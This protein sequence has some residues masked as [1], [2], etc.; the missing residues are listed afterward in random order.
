MIKQMDLVEIDV[1][2]TE[3]MQALVDFGQDCLSR[4]AATVR[5][6]PH[7]CANLRRKNDF[8]TARKVT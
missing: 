6:R 4:Q 3:P 1:V 2:G 8:V 5:A 7:R